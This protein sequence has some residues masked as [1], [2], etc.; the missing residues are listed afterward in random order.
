MSQ[1]QFIVGILF[2]DNDNRTTA[3]EDSFGWVANFKRFLE[4]MLEQVSGAF[5]SVVLFSESD[6][7]HEKLRACKVLIPVISR[8][9]LRSSPCQEALNTFFAAKSLGQRLYKV[10]KVPIDP[11]E[12][13]EELRYFKGYDL[14]KYN[15]E[16]GEAFQFRDFF[17]FEARGNYWMKLVDLAFDI[18]ESIY[19]IE[20][21]KSSIGAGRKIYLAETTTDLAVA[22]NVIRRELMRFGFEILPKAPLPVENYEQALQ[23]ALNESFLSIHLIGGAYGALLPGSPLSAIDL[24]NRQA[25]QHFSQ[26]ANQKGLS[27]VIWI[28]PDQVDV[29]ERQLAFITNLKRDISD[30]EGAEVFQTSLE[31]F[32]NFL[33]KE[34]L[35][36]QG[37]SGHLYRST[38][39]RTSMGSAP[40]FY[41]I[42]DRVDEKAV[43][44]LRSQFEQ[45]GF[46]V[47]TPLFSGDLLTLR[48]HHL[49]K[50]RSFDVALIYQG[51]VNGK[52]VGVKLLD[53]LKAPGFG[54]NKPILGRILVMETAG[55]GQSPYARSEHIEL[56]QGNSE[57]IKVRL[58][59]YIGKLLST[60]TDTR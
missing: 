32:K 42:Y 40:Q 43:G 31:D 15:L 34:L 19:Q 10:L 57:E 29:S 12:Q 2:S 58:D 22:R 53:L 37:R 56:I 14:Y 23:T 17:D 26:E 5:P 51:R 9:F 52:W 25:A 39:A 41:L 21:E 30:Q 49:E 27:R 24:Q 45:A 28:S 3:T 54:R 44:P 46:E 60:T 33:R 1:E 13:P 47:S 35:D 4:P 7:D 6:M 48:Q 36:V 8:D 38:G 59:E 16:S 18:Q 11:Q 55:E 50:L 20:T